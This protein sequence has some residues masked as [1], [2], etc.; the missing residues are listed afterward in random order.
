VK[1]ATARV[2]KT[3]KWNEEQGENKENKDETFL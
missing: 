2:Q 3:V 1:K